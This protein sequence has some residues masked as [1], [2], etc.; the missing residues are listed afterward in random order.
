MWVSIKNFAVLRY[1]LIR[2]KGCENRLVHISGLHRSMQ[3]A[4]RNQHASGI[5]HLYVGGN[6]TQVIPQL[7]FDSDVPPTFGIYG[8]S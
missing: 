4:G 2:D 1:N 8:G 6:A 7:T 5:Y 3:G